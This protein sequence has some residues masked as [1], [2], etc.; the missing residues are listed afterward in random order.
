[1]KDD[2]YVFDADNY[3]VVGKRTGNVYALGD[4]AVIKVRRADLI[5]KQLDFEF[6]SHTTEKPIIIRNEKRYKKRK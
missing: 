3:R 1:M 5:K 2:N 6:V 4:K